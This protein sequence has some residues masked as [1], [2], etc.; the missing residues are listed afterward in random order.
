MFCHPACPFTGGCTEEIKTYIFMKSPIR[1]LG[2]ALLLLS[3]VG[4]ATAA[5]KIVKAAPTDS[6]CETFGRQLADAVNRGEP[7]KMVQAMDFQAFGDRVVKGLDLNEPD[8]TEFIKGLSNGLKSTME[9]QFKIW[10]T[11][12][13]IRV[14]KVEGE[15]RILVRVLSEKGSMN[16]LE[17]VC[18]PNAAGGLK[19]V[20]C[21]PYITAELMSQTSR[22]SVLP[23]LAEKKKGFIERL[24]SNEN[25]YVRHFPRIKEALAAMQTGDG[26]KAS[27][28]LEALPDEVKMM[29]SVLTMRLQAS[30]SVDEKIYLRVISDWEKARPGDPSLDLVAIDGG[31]LRKDYADCLRRINSLEKRVGPDGW[32][33]CLKSVV[34]NLMDDLVGARAALKQAIAIEPTLT[35][36]YDLWF[37]IELKTKDWA[38]LVEAVTSFET[39][40]P[41]ANIWDGIKE[42]A[43][44]AEFRESKECQEWFAQREKSRAAAPREPAAP[45][46]VTEEAHAPTPNAKPNAD[47]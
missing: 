1:W 11:A 2:L 26:K 28:I 30:Q 34:M 37:A 25:F 43:S 35:N 22:R 13:F 5:D 47:Q 10:K 32:L 24:T 3:G 44:W 9:S 12:R 31:F 18:A 39:N 16:F 38:H 46:A 7:L 41:N 15:K 33:E 14:T 45:A 20:D 6:E 29:P 23:F 17:W 40:F 42:D 4:C 21:Y 19:T 36:S 27:A 8:R